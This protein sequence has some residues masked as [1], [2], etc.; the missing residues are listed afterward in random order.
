MSFNVTGTY[1]P[2][3]CDFFIDVGEEEILF[4]M[5]LN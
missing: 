1:L 5:D 4:L 3:V 2:P